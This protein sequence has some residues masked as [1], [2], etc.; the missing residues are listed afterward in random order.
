MMQ[1]VDDRGLQRALL[2]PLPPNLII[3]SGHWHSFADDAIVLPCQGLS[4]SE[5]LKLVCSR[6]DVPDL[7]IR[8][9]LPEKKVIICLHVCL[10]DDDLLQLAQAPCILH[11]LRL[12]LATRSPLTIRC[13]SVS[14]RY[15]DV[16]L[17]DEQ[18]V[19]VLADKLPAP[20]EL[21]AYL[22]KTIETRD[23]DELI[24][25]VR[26]YLPIYQRL[27]SENP[28]TA[29]TSMKPYFNPTLQCHISM[30]DGQVSMASECAFPGLNRMSLFILTASFLASYNP[31][32]SDLL[33]FQHEKRRK[34][35]RPNRS[36]PGK[37]EKA[38]KVSQ[39]QIGPKEFALDRMLEILRHICC[40]ELASSDVYTHISNLVAM[41]FLTILS[42]NINAGRSV[43]DAT[44]LR[45]LVT[46]HTAVNMA[47]QVGLNLS[48][49]LYDP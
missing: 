38:A 44:K 24:Y 37:A 26:Q 34:G 19:G 49:Y 46:F 30:P 31:V 23:V 28:N 3:V 40:D 43:L 47:R 11:G 36:E 6:L 2:N 45:C 18:L 35:R 9:V 21:V 17:T 5:V 41:R 8:A 29:L 12:V 1:I 10:G 48:H 4:A 16:R 42:A 39:L 33:V 7:L 13:S 25:L 14:P 20:G 32:G 22:L 27:L 15:I